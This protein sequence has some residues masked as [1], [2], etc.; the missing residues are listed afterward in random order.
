MRD[1]PLKGS[2][3][4]F[5]FGSLSSEFRG[6]VISVFFL[7]LGFVVIWVSKTLLD[8]KGDALYISLLIVP[9]LI[10]AVATGRIR[11]L[12]GPGGTGA[13]FAENAD[14]LVNQVS[15]VASGQLTEMFKQVDVRLSA[16]PNEQFDARPS[17]PTAGPFTFIDT[18]IRAAQAQQS[19]FTLVNLGLGE[20]WLSTRLYLLAALIEDYSSIKTIAFVAPT[21]TSSN[22]FVGMAPPRSIR[23]A[24]GQQ[25]PVLETNYRQALASALPGLSTEEERSQILNSMS[26]FLG[27]QETDA[28]QWVTPSLLRLWLGPELSTESVDWADEYSIPISLIR[29]IIKRPGPYVALISN[30]S[31]VRVVDRCELAVR[32][33]ADYLADGQQ[34]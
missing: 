13:K 5:Q 16:L 4:S 34:P 17:D 24:L 2:M 33:A 27:Y 21:E 11:E 31:L 1:G 25:N 10:W 23:R 9:I 18:F 15:Q 3:R 29:S 12:T 6:L 32:L 30:G 8:V 14:E 22:H 26:L 20:S 7:L 28:R 19:D